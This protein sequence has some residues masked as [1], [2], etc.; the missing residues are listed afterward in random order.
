VNTVWKYTFNLLA[1]A[2]GYGLPLAR[3]VEKAQRGEQL[4]PDEQDLLDA[5]NRHVALSEI[6]MA[7]ERMKNRLVR[8]QK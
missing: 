1:A 3:I 8:W 7:S 6:R 2:T 4:H 5:Y